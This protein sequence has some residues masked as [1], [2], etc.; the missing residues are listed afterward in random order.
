[1]HEA[2]ALSDD[3]IQKSN[4]VR[5]SDSMIDPVRNSIKGPIGGSLQKSLFPKLHES[6]ANSKAKGG[7]PRVIFPCVGELAAL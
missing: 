6:G 2:K 4:G 7:Q 1:M 3:G 5:F